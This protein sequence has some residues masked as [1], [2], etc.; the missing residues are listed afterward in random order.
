VTGPKPMAN[1][2]SMKHMSSVR[3]T[4]QGRQFPPIG[5]T[6]MASGLAKSLTILETPK[7][8]GTEAHRWPSLLGT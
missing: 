2:R 5:H 8:R 7:L 6:A 1:S 3:R 4:R